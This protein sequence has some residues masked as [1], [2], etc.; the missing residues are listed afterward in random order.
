MPA[1]STSG[2]GPRANSSSPG[3]SK[4]RLSSIARSPR[5]LNS[6]T[7][8][9]STIGPTGM[10]PSPTMVNAGRFWSIAPGVSCRKVSIA[11]RALAKPRALPSTCACHPRSTTRQSAL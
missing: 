1:N 6:T 10:P 8:A 2:I 5:K 9:P 11:S 7:D 3:S 4:A